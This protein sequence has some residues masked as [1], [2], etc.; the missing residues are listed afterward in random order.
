MKVNGKLARMPTCQSSLIP[1]LQFE[2]S[3]GIAQTGSYV[4]RS[5]PA[6]ATQ[7][8]WSMWFSGGTVKDWRIAESL[9]HLTNA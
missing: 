7:F 3:L 1:H 5:L 9:I 2:S 8:R 4:V 6:A